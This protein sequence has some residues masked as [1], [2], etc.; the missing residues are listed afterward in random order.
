MYECVRL[1]LPI[2]L[3]LPRMH[4]GRGSLHSTERNK[5]PLFI[6]NPLLWI[7]VYFPFCPWEP[8]VLKMLDK[9][10]SSGYAWAPLVSLA[11][12]FSAFFLVM[13]CKKDQ[14]PSFSLCS[15]GQTVDRVCSVDRDDLE[16]KTTPLLLSP[17][18]CCW[19]CKCVLP[20]LFRLL[21]YLRALLKKL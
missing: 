20:R 17:P 1:Y 21:G 5:R 11:G 7:R 9:H 6:T 16:F 19:N 10:S 2:I 4:K 15:P 13:P 14:I 12:L 8:R 3:Y 18:P